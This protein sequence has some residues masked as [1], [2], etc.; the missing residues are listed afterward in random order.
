MVA[1]YHNDVP[2]ATS[3]IPLTGYG[4]NSLT[5]LSYLATTII[6]LHSFSQLL[7]KKAAADRSVE[8]PPLGLEEGKESV[9]VGLSK[10]EKVPSNVLSSVAV[11]MEYRRKSGRS[12]GEWYFLR[13][14]TGSI[15]PLP[16]KS[17]HANKE[18]FTLLDDHPLWR[19]KSIDLETPD[20]GEPQSTFSLSL[21]DRQR[22]DRE[23]VVLPYF[24]A[25][26][27]EGGG[28]GGRILYDMGVEDDFDEEEDEI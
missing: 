2:L 27:V 10:N 18:N 1:V 9:L 28:E 21:T 11:E 23:G 26:N 17:A 4:P 6:T 3:N 22:H 16:A 19:V 7:V 14:D 5:L 25:Q 12:V 8:P 24:D 13:A 20:N 15:A